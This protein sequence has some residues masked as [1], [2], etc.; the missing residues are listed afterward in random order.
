MKN[1]K[2]KNT[3]I[4]QDTINH[5]L[6]IARIEDVVSEFVTINKKGANYTGLCPFHN[7]KT[8]SFMVF[9]AD[10]H[11]HCF[12]CGAHG[13]AVSFLMEYKKLS[14][15][16]ALK[17]LA[18]KYNIT[19]K[20]D[21]FTP[22]QE[23]IQKQK[24]QLTIFY[25]FM[26]D[27][28]RENLYKAENA[29]ALEYIKSRFSD[30]TIQKFQLGYAPNEYDSLAK[31]AR[32]EGYPEDDL[33][34]TG[35]IRQNKNTRQLYDFFRN[36]IIF[37]I[38]DITGNII[39][40][41]GRVLP[42]ADK[43]YGKYINGTTTPVYSKRLNLFALNF[44][45]RQI[46][47]TG[48][49]YLVEGNPDV[50]RL[51]QIGITNSVAS[52]GTAL[53]DE[54]INLLKRYAKK[55]VM[56]YDSDNAG[57]N[58]KNK[59]GI[60]L[61]KSQLDT[62]LIALPKGEDPDSFFTSKQ[63]FDEFIEKNKKDFILE[64]ANTLFTKAGKDPL[65]KNEAV[66]EIGNLL[67]TL[68]KSKQSIYVE[69]ISKANQTKIKIF[70][71]FFK[72][73][74]RTEKPAKG[75]ETK[76][77][78]PEGVDANDL[79]KWGFYAHNN[80]Y[81]FRTK[82]GFQKL[83]NFVMRPIFHVDSVID[84]K[85]I[86]EL[87]NVY[88][89]KT[90]VDFDMQEMT[91]IQ[92]FQRN[93]EGRGN[94]MFW[95]TIAHFQK[96]KR[97]LYMETRTCQEIKNL[98]WQKEGFWAWSNGKTTDEGLFEEIDEYGIITHNDVN[99]FIPAFSKIY[100]HDKSLFMDE[101]KFKF[102][103]R[104]ISL[105][106]WAEMF[107]NVF[108]DNA[109]ISIAFWIATV[110]RDF[111]LHTFKNFP[112]LN[113][114]GP[115][116]TGKSQLAMSM[117]CLFGEQQTPFNIHN[118]TKPGLA[119]HLQLFKNAFA[120]VDEYKNNLEYDKIETLKA[121][122]D[123]IGRSRMNLN[124]GMKKETTQVNAGVILSGQ[125][126]PTIDVA[127]F[128]RVIFLQ[129]NKTEFN[130]TE[131]KDYEELKQAERDGLSHLT[132]QIL[133]HRKYFEKNFYHHY[134][135][136]VAEFY[137]E[138]K[139]L[140]IEDRI[141]RNM[142]TIVASFKTIA[143]KINFTYSYSDLKPVAFKAMQ[144]QNSQISLSSEVGMFWNLLEALFDDNLI[145]DRW[146]FR[147]DMSSTLKLKTRQLHLKQAHRVLK[148]KFNIIYKLYAQQSRNQGIKP[149]PS[150]TLQYYLRNSKHFYGIQD[151]TNFSISEY[152]KEKGKTIK[153]KQNT[154]AF[155]FDYDELEINLERSDEETEAINEINGKKSSHDVSKYAMAVE[156]KLPF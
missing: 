127:L 146:H 67:L 129:F 134:E 12:G 48:T 59:N 100:I 126:M 34:S 66:K 47:K 99:Y 122:Y 78:I 142:A 101:R 56:I 23:K 103:N 151:K 64:Y 84:S 106:K 14:Y 83:S 55:I 6:Q 58:A 24:Q 120:W 135:E 104:D 74:E 7:E 140:N 39:S 86:Y 108:G 5:I 25:R 155:C 139:K 16:E 95:G 138:T 2:S 4:C 150:D 112:I 92:A 63:K 102:V 90:V 87:E 68:E 118:G 1:I 26:A 97:K 65:Q 72:D 114:F 130:E 28:Y 37:P 41:T 144:D 128:S 31:F 124:K 53:S 35:F 38:T 21:K 113:L 89:Y 117:S 88:G 36:R 148:F 71:D 46:A 77:A 30:E 137:E 80:E 119:E 61:V 121:I 147:I 42:G 70:S 123:A 82:D 40:L 29:L 98:G 91:S 52:L 116:G 156:D 22:E 73:K 75:A 131:K 154:T 143:E 19:I 93:I 3:L 109:K 60:K 105:Q 62:Y 136:V 45:I 13:N 141:L 94:F 15:P 11:Y 8:P 133:K 149:L 33:L 32:S 152:D 153:R 110:F 44:A 20:E 111:L 17:E 79:E 115:K 132:A 54:Q 51:H 10:N 81:S 9:P 43:K 18:K 76:K 57:Q 69:Q 85:R 125:E 96:L 107:I 50:I 145:V 27:F 49:V